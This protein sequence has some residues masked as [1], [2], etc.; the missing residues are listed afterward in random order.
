M[1]VEGMN[2]NRA[3]ASSSPQTEAPAA[4]NAKG[5]IMILLGV[6]AATVLIPVVIVIMLVVG[7]GHLFT[8]TTTGATH[9]VGT[10]VKEMS[11]P[12]N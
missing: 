12:A 4:S 1:A 11:V 6:L 8:S 5:V 10:V 9:A 2:D 7:F 3:P